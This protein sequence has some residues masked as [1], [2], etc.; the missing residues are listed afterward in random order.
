MF[1]RNQDWNGVG[2]EDFDEEMRGQ[3]RESQARAHQERLIKTE[4]KKV[5]NRDWRIF[6]D[7][8][9][10]FFVM[11]IRVGKDTREFHFSVPI[12]YRILSNWKG[13][14]PSHEWSK[15]IV[16]SLKKHFE[17]E[18]RKANPLYIDV[19]EELWPIDELLKHSSV[20]IEEE[21]DYIPEVAVNQSRSQKNSSGCNS[22]ELDPEELFKG[23]ETEGRTSSKS[24]RE[25]KEANDEEGSETECEATATGSVE[26]QTHSQ[27]LVSW[28]QFLT[29]KGWYN[30]PKDQTSPL[31]LLDPNWGC[32][33]KGLNDSHAFEFQEEACLA[34]PFSEHP[35]A[36]FQFDAKV[37]FE[38]WNYNFSTQ[39][40]NYVYELLDC[41][42]VSESS[43]KLSKASR[44]HRD[45]AVMKILEDLYSEGDWV[46]ESRRREYIFKILEAGFRV[47][48]IDCEKRSKGFNST[49]NLNVLIGNFG[50]FSRSAKPLHPRSSA[51]QFMKARPSMDPSDNLLVRLI[52][53]MSSHLVVLCE[54]GAITERE[55][56]YLEHQGHFSYAQNQD[57]THTVL[58]RG[59]NCTVVG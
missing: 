49:T 41:R 36:L 25:E 46:E 48:E 59:E 6:L 39:S 28:L 33:A 2:F 32:T 35:H 43:A 4:E 57:K 30:W 13:E 24:V 20:T 45:R 23:S 16:K 27:L 3:D 15:N 37:I 51:S 1:F 52:E 7:M 26:E 42:V 17:K 8:F 11:L 19:T 14:E 12:I 29:Q 38:Q 10:S 34:V 22:P 31:R 50:N 9:F 54:S 5:L 21:M 40:D 47:K 44:D 18:T 53:G 58:I 56:S 55:L